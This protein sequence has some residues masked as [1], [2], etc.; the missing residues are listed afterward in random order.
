[1][2]SL[3]VGLGEIGSS[4]KSLI[5]KTDH[6]MTHDIKEFKRGKK[7]THI[8]ILH[9]CFPPSQ[10]FVQDVKDYITRWEPEHV[11]IW[12]STPIGTIK[13]IPGAVHTPVEGRHPVLNESLKLMTRWLG[14][15]DKLEARF[16]KG[17][18][19][20][21]Y[22]E[23]EVVADSDFTEALKLLSTTEYGVNIEFARYKKSVADE[24]GMDYELTKRWNQD[25]NQLY[26]YLGM[27]WAQKFVLDAPEGPK[28]GHCVTPNARL[29]QEQFPDALVKIVG[30]L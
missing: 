21:M 28:G 19:K 4:V 29:L 12:S 11:L 5:E 14:A 1:M 9:I 25:Y 6:V 10:T 13:Q 8:D 20:N 15:N 27:D 3:I 7:S 18:F 2:N 26:K 22:L 17:Y 23:V 16:F 24:L 30:E